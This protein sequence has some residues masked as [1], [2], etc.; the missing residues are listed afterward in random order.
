MDAISRGAIDT[1]QGK[2]GPKK[3]KR[4]PAWRRVRAHHMDLYKRCAACDRWKKRHMLEVHHIQSFHEWPILE[5]EPTNLITLCRR[6]HQLLGHLN[7][8]RRINPMIR[9]DAYALRM[10]IEG[11]K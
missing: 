10:K 3:A 6:C 4:S 7:A 1:L 11:A 5:L 9:S 2:D 8:W